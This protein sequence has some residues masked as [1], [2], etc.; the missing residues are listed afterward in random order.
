VPVSQPVLS[1]GPTT[2]TLPFP[3]S[4]SSTRS[5]WDSVGGS[6]MT[7]NGS[8]RVWSVGYRYQYALAFEYCDAATYDALVALFWSNVS[9]QTTTTFLWSGGPW[10]SATTSVEVFVEAI[11]PL[12]TP[13]PDV[14]RGDFS[15]TLVEA[16]AR[17]T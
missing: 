16:D 10:S 9:E 8:M 12:T 3:N 4:S 13:Y 2:I 7:V 15:V 6:R 14:S 5:T 11:S 17:T 1:S